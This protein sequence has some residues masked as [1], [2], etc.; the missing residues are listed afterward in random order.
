MY[1]KTP[2]AC[3]VSCAIAATTLG[4]SPQVLAQAA[5]S[6]E[7]IEE[8][9]VTGS[10]IKR[11]G[12]SAAQ[13][14]DVILT[15]QA[16]SRGIADVGSLLQSTT[17]AAGSSQVTS[18]TSS[19]FIQNGGIG[20]TTLSLRG[21][22]PNRTLTL[23]NGR[24]AGPAGTRGGTSS[25]DLNILPLAALERVEILKD[26]A[27]SVYGSDAVAGVVNFITKKGDG[28][29][30]DVY[31]SQPT[32]SGGEE[33]RISASWGKSFERGNFRIT[34]DY[35]KQE[36]LARGDRDYFTCGEQYI[37]DP[38]SGQRR[39][40]I[41]PRTGN[42]W[43]SDQLW[44]HVW[45]YDY[46]DPSNVP[47]AGSLLAQYDYDGDLG[48]YIPGYAPA[49]N[50]DQ[51]G[52][53]A[54][55]FPVRYDVAS[56]SVTN[57]NHPFQNAESLI[58][59]SEFTTIYADGEFDLT[60]NMTVYAELLLN[61]RETKAN[62][63]RQYWTY[64]YNENSNG[65]DS[66]APGAGDPLSAGW[67]GAN[68]MSPT[69]IT[70][71][72][73][74][75]IEVNYSRFVAGLKGDLND[76]WSYDIAY[77]YSLSDGDY[78]SEQIYNDSIEDNWMPAF[79]G[80]GVGTCVGTVSSVNGLP[81]VDIPWLDPALLAGDIPQDVRDFIF[82]V[83]TGNTEYT[84][85]SLEGY[86]TGTLF[87]MPAGSVGAVGGVHYRED[88]INDVPGELTLS[89]NAWGTSVAGITAGDDSTTAVF[90]ELEFPLLVDAPFARALT[91][92]VSGRYTDVESYGDGTTYKVNGDWQIV[93]SFRIRA[94]QGTSFRT[95]AL[96]EL[97]LADE[98]SSIRQAAVDPCINWA[99][100]AIDGNITA[101]IAA[102]CQADGV[103]PD[104]SVAISAT[105]ISSGGLGLLEAETS[106]SRSAGF[107]WTPAFTELSLSVDYFDYDVEDE[108]AQLGG[109]NIVEGC[110]QSD[111]FPNEPL[112]DLFER[113]AIDNGVD[114]IRNAYI[115]IAT[116]RNTGYDIAA[117]WRTDIGA[118][119]LTLD[120]QA[121]VQT[122]ASRELFPGNFEDTNGELGEPELVGRLFTYYD[123]GPWTLFWGANYI[124]SVSNVESFG[125]TTTT[126]RG[127]TVGLVLDAPSIWYHAFSV[128]R[129]FENS[130]ITAVL[131]VANAFDEEPPQVSS[132]TL[133]RG[134][135]DVVGRAAFYSQYDW[136]GRRYYLNLSW[137]MQ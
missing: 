64:I 48:Q 44:G 43:C 87:E 133:Q 101:E 40:T 26:G 89:G 107:V 14:I 115:N 100:N 99:Q 46:A 112:C 12:F 110:Y 81:C 128:T 127:E 56:D 1:R 119:T 80:R 84:Q 116:Q 72:S 60:D 31:L 49:A 16:V 65:G 135:L 130:G 30:V 57:S 50:P 104:H 9:M 34:A 58:P 4:I 29:T 59:E 134:E 7:V 97:Y 45:L 90:G 74:S 120:G 93:D 109:Q 98:T 106:T 13:P 114:N 67:T 131:G 10:R 79:G 37:F 121:T 8:I 125:G 42:P 27:S 132:G 129:E 122:E 102:N 91:L 103:A 71:H 88:E 83:E 22:G 68:W 76:N 73:D 137:N 18:A 92:G 66:P 53:P 33:S 17:I 108:V 124:D 62:G 69:P 86:V 24:R 54:G 105:S 111:F 78:T 61:R 63:Y 118:G 126:Y 28:A 82:G 41:D 47:T 38:D 70:D 96:F 55:F 35:M 19:E 3:A 21:L 136:L 117:V 77:Q 11:D 123:H 39:D 2:L 51:L 32:E 95:P 6:V 36:E 85:W 75:M 25:F 94:S 15:D 52:A 5:D 113:R 20:A 23:L